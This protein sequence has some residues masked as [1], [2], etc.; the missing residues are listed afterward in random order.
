MLTQ[1][2]PNRA[3]DGECRTL[4][5][6]FPGI[7]SDVPDDAYPARHGDRQRRRALRGRPAL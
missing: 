3:G 6:Q 2:M 5:A 1:R 7:A 4:S